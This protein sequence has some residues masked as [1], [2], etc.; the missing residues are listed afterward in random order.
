MS[1]GSAS[2]AIIAS[3]AVPATFEPLYFNDLYLADGAVSSSTPI[4]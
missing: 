3:A 1:E 4:T 2:Q